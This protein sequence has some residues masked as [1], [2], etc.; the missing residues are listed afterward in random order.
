MP[1]K[2]IGPSPGSSTPSTCSLPMD[3]TPGLKRLLRPKPALSLK[4]RAEALGFDHGRILDELERLESERN[5]L[6]GEMRLLD[7]EADFLEPL[8]DVALPLE[9]FRG[10]RTAEVRLVVL[11]VGSGEARGEGARKARSGSRS[12]PGTSV[13][14]APSSSSP[15]SPSTRSRPCSRSSGPNRSTS[16]PGSRRPAPA[17]RSRTCLRRTGSS[18][19]GK[20]RATKALEAEMTRP[21]RPR[22]RPDAGLRRS[23]E[24]TGECSS[25]GRLPGETESRELSRR[26]GA[27]RGQGAPREEGRR[28]LRRRPGLFPRTASR[29]GTAGLPGESA[30]SPSPFEII[31]SL[32]GLPE[33]GYLDPTLPLAPFFFIYVG[34]CVSEGGYGFLVTVLSLLY[35]KFGRP[36]KGARLFAKLALYLGTVQHRPGDVLRR[37]VRVPHQLAPPHRPV[38]RPHPVPRSVAS[39]WASSRSGS[40]RS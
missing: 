22:P 20:S 19:A 34:L 24:R 38:E 4:A 12:S 10:T 23:A 21:G 26:L 11:P 14:A 8:R 7:R 25:P 36:S 28:G 6:S 1:P 2:P 30:G 17:K 3:E 18:A 27:G 9:A 37:L 39:S 35:L 40:E 16:M 31:T 29:R 33:R 5:A 13:P 32:Y 15:A